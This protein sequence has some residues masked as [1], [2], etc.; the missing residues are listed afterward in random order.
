METVEA[1][2]DLCKKLQYHSHYLPIFGLA[3][4]IAS[5]RRNPLGLSLDMVMIN[6]ILNRINRGANLVS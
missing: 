2:E 5:K 1:L 4:G 3:G 6:R